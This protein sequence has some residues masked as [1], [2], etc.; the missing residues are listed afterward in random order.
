MDTIDSI[1]IIAAAWG[2]LVLRLTLALILWPHGAQKVLGWFGGAG[3]DGTYQAFTGKMGIPPLPGQGGHADG[4]FRPH[5]PGA[6]HL[7][8]AS[9]ALRHHH[10]GR[11]HD[12]TC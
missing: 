10:D 7:H 12:Q 6:G 5:L 1:T 11:R 8:Q 9:G 3:W 4:I 2:L